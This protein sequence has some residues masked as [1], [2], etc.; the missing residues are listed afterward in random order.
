MA[1]DVAVP[2]GAVVV[3]RTGRL[4]GAGYPWWCVAVRSWSTTGYRYVHVTPARSWVCK[5]GVPAVASRLVAVVA[6]AIDGHATLADLAL[7]AAVERLPR[8][9]RGMAAQPCL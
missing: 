5:R 3:I 1:S 4:S 2:V 7:V 9:L 8:A 6:G